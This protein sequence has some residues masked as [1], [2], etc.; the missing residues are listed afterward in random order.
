[1]TT[2][3]QANVT[4]LEVRQTLKEVSFIVEQLA[5]FDTQTGNV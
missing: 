1:M 5:S 2:C 4:Y 3:Q